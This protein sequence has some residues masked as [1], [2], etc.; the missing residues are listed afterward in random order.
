MFLTRR[1]FPAAVVF[2]SGATMWMNRF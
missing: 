2:S 1:S